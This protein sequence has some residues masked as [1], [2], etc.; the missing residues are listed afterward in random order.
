MKT[1]AKTGEIFY[2]IFPLQNGEKHNTND[3]II[4]KRSFNK[5]N[6]KPHLNND[7]TNFKKT[8]NFGHDFFCTL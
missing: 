1:F 6:N 4:Y 7:F 8:I 2:Q 5:R 3:K